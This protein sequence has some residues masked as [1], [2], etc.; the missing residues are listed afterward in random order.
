MTPGV[1]D[2]LREQR[3]RDGVLRTTALLD[4]NREGG[5]ATL[6]VEPRPTGRRI[7]NSH[8]VGDSPNSHEALSGRQLTWSQTRAH[9]AYAHQRGESPCARL[10]THC[11]VALSRA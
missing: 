2:G 10:E 11:A 3:H 5:E 1:N 9:R 4:P 8:Y 7:R 6:A